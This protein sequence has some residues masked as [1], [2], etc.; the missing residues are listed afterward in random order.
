MSGASGGRARFE[1]FEPAV[2]ALVAVGALAV[3]LLAP[4]YPNYD[5][6]YHLVWGRELLHGHVPSFD[7]YAAPTQHPLLVALGG[8]L[9]LLGTIGDRGLVAVT[10]ASLVA[11]VWATYRL[12]ARVFGRWP[13]LAAAVFVGTSTSLLL[14][15]ARGYVDMPFLA[16]VLWAAALEVRSPRRGRLVM[17]L[18]AGAGLLRPEAWPLAAAYWLWCRAG[19]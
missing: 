17:A 16:L 18:L 15:A 8:A 11:T 12:G 7:A 2:V 6:Y 19:A 13:G 5:S 9:S 1:R 14:Y 3:Y 4:T 10:V